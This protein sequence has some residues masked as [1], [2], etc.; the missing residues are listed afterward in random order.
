M[1]QRLAEQADGARLSVVD[2]TRT[3]LPPP[4]LTPRESGIVYLMSAGHSTPEIASM[5]ELRP[6]TV[7]NHKRHIYEKLG[8]SSQSHAVA[9]AISLGLLDLPGRR[10]LGPDRGDSPLGLVRGPVGECRHDV[11]GSLVTHGLS[12]VVV[13]RYGRPDDAH[14]ERWHRGP[15]AVVLVD[16]EPAD[17]SLP[18]SLEAPTVVVR[19]G[20]R[21]QSAIVDALSRGAS[22]LVFVEDVAASLG[23]VLR[24]VARGLFAMSGVYAGALAK[25]AVDRASAA[26]QLTARECDIL[27][28]IASG[29]TIRQTARALGIAAKT[30]EATQARLFRKLG[31]RNRTETL[32][33]AD[34]WGLV[35]WATTRIDPRPVVPSHAN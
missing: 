12:F 33:I 34:R 18:A 5:L 29:H 30:V 1:D 22:G 31:A 35:D 3:G 7:E 4:R 14:W 25:W 27:R 19:S 8:V 26:P 6:R 10:R 15:V 9:L 32:T 16:P 13:D 11:L 17:W 23:P 20:A 28:S 2:G 21:D 24:I